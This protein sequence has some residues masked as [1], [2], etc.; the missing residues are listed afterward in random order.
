MS[1]TQELLLRIGALE[2][3]IAQSLKIDQLERELIR[4]D[5]RKLF[6]KRERRRL[7][8][9]RLMAEVDQIAAAVAKQIETRGGTTADG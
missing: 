5:V 1:N 9:L 2:R 6:K 8:Q 7:Q 4:R 3:D